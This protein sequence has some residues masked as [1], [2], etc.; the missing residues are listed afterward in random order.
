[1]CRRGDDTRLTGFH[2]ASNSKDYIH[3]EA[4]ADFGGTVTL[5]RDSDGGLRITNGTKHPLENCRVIQ[6]AD[7]DGEA[8]LFTVARL[9]PGATTRLK[10]SD[11]TPFDRN[12]P[13]AAVKAIIKLLEPAADRPEPTGELSAGSVAQ[14]ALGLQG[15]RPGEVCLAARIADEVPGLTVTPDT[16]Q[17]R[18]AALLV[19]HLDPGKLPDPE[20]DND[21]RPK[22]SARAAPLPDSPRGEIPELDPSSP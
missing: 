17:F 22:G 9:D 21:M 19:A 4:M 18:Q 20:P 11:S 12:A 14:V 10:D 8:R 13:A 15:M 1:V 2:V 3:S 6:N 16:R 7:H 5:H